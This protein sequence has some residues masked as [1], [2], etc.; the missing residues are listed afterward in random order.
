MTE[1]K[2]RA[3]VLGSASPL[4]EIPR[5]VGFWQAGLLDLEGMVTARRPLEEINEATADLRAGRGIRTVM[6]I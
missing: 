2:L 3:S 4:K 5:M 1:K 6:L